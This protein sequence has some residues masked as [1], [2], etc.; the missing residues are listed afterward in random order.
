MTSSAAI[1]LPSANLRSL[2]RLNVSTVR[3]VFHVADSA[4]YGALFPLYLSTP[5]AGAS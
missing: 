3:S 2:R 5:S 4:R 1:A